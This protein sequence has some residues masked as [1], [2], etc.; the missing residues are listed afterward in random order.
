MSESIITL[1]IGASPELTWFITT[2]LH[3]GEEAPPP[4]IDAI[5]RSWTLH[6]R[7]TAWAI[8]RRSTGWTLRK[9]V[10][11]WQLEEDDR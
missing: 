5:V 3:V 11:N 8:E 6:D 4:D 9:R 1:G 10:R 7:T 2:G